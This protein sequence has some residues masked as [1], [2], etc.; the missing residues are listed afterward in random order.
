M[1]YTEYWLF[2]YTMHMCKTQACEF[3]TEW[4]DLQRQWNQKNPLHE[5]LKQYLDP[6]VKTLV[7]GM[8]YSKTE[9]MMMEGYDAENSGLADRDQD[10]SPWASHPSFRRSS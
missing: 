4:F 3:W 1:I 6:L 10:I 2:S 7:K 9:L 8:T 5:K